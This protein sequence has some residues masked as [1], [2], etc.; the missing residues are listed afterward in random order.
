MLQITG[1]LGTGYGYQL[2]PGVA[3]LEKN[4]LAR[5]LANHFGD[6]GETV[7]FHGANFLYLISSVVPSLKFDPMVD[8]FGLGMDPE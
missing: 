2:Y 6:S 1:N 8:K 5:D 3:K 7:V 4:C